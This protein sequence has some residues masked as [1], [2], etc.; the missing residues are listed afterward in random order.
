MMGVFAVGSGQYVLAIK[1][2]VASCEV[3]HETRYH[4][5]QKVGQMLFGYG[6]GFHCFEVVYSKVLWQI[7][8]PSERVENEST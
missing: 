5:V 4:V 6:S 3:V 8:G 7:C 2:V 1:R